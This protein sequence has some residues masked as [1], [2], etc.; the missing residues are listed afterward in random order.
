MKAT[1]L[2][3]TFICLLPAAGALGADH[4]RALDVFELEYASDPRISPDGQRIVYVRNSMDIMEDRKRTKLWIINFDGRDPR[5]LTDGDG[6]E[7]SPRWSPDGTRI[8]YISDAE[9]SSQIYLRWMDSGQNAKLT[10]VLRSPRGITWS[11]DGQWIAFSMLVP[12]DP[13]QIARLPKKPEGANWA[14]PPRII[15]R[16]C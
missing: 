4:F 3:L 13:P 10:Q 16:R 11:P 7:S 6:Q 8:A 1:T 15:S 14:D 9:G 5:R 2:L 12:D